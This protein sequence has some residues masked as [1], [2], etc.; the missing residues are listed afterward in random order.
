MRL[1]AREIIRREVMREQVAQAAVDG[2]E[3]LSGTVGRDVIGA[4]TLARRC[5][6]GRIPW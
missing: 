4:A 5:G 3:I 6:T 2:V 1:E